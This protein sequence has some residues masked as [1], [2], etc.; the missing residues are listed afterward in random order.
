[1]PEVG[2]VH[3]SSVIYVLQG[4]MWFLKKIREK[5]SE[6]IWVFIAGIPFVKNPGLS[7]LHF[8]LK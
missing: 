1:M 3:F 8:R 7:F 4:Y 5:Y 6:R 2:L